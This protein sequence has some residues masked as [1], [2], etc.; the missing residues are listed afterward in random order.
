MIRADA[1]QVLKIL[2]AP[3]GFTIEP[4]TMDVWFQAALER[5][6]PTLATEVAVRLV[7]KEERF[8]TPAR[9]NAE[10]A[11]VER[12]RYEAIRAAAPVQGQI[13]PVPITRE[14][15]AEW[16]AEMRRML[17]PLGRRGT[18]G[19]DHRGPEPCPVCGGISPDAL[20]QMTATEQDVATMTLRRR[21]DD[22]RRGR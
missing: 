22:R 9:F 6:D 19:H 2:S 8:P 1:A 3:H 7:E 16:I 13:P 11:G 12:E 10:R 15:R 18:R 20:V 17:T 14:E 21:A 5:C 4:D